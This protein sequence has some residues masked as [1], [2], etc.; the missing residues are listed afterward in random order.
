MKQLACSA[1]LAVALRTRLPRS[2]PDARVRWA[3]LM[4]ALVVL[5]TREPALREASLLGATELFGHFDR[6]R[7][8][9][10]R[11]ARPSPSDNRQVGRDDRGDFGVAAGRL[12]IGE[13]QD[14][15]SRAGH[16]DR[17]GHNR[18]RDDVPAAAMLEAGAVEAHAHPV[19]ALRNAEFG[20]EECRD[21]FLGKIFLLRAE[22][23]ADRLI[24][25]RRQR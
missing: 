14:R 17:A 25:G 16:L 9:A 11:V 15:L 10:Q 1:L 7:G 22:D 18:I 8:K 6:D 3:D 2:P 20:A 24:A 19:G 4:R 23:D 13:Q 21:C 12:V 5:P